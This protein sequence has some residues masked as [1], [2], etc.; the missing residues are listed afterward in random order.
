MR[1]HVQTNEVA[2]LEKQLPENS[3]QRFGE[4]TDDCRL[5]VLSHMPLVYAMAW[6]LR[7]KGISQDDLQQEG[8]LGLCEAAT[9]YD[10][11]VDCS[12]ATY[13]SYW[14][15]KMMLRV[16]RRGRRTA[17]NLSVEQE[18]EQESHDV[19]RLGQQHRIADA[20]KDLTAKERQVVRLTYGIDTKQLSFTEIAARMGISKTSVS[21][22]HRQALHRLEAALMRRPL[23]D[24]LGPWL[25]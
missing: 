18:S 7:D 9:R 19:L 25:E 12:F 20:L 22:I 13:A 14:C 5:L 17:G 15:R 21:V 2:G 6:R 8:F 3:T 4:L 24:Y 1:Q 10:E 16:I 23:V 11:N